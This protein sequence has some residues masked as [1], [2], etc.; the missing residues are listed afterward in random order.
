MDLRLSFLLFM[1]L[2]SLSAADFPGGRFQRKN[3]CQGDEDCPKHNY[4]F[5]SYWV[6][7]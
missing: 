4:C 1:S 7:T 3:E 2:V 6:G 5:H